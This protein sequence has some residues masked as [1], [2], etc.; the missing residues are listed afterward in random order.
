MN[1]S[2]KKD[3]ILSDEEKNILFNDICLRFNLYGICGC[4]C[5][6]NQYEVCLIIHYFWYAEM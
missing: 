5:L 1:L 3:T 4:L 2:E 6:K